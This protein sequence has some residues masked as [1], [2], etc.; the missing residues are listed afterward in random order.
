MAPK[1]LAAKHRLDPGALPLQHL[2]AEVK[3]Q[4]FDLGK[5]Q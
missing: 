4:G 1:A 5:R 2:P 3:Q